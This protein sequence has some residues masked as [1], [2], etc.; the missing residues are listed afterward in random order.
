[1]REFLRAQGVAFDPET[2]E[3]MVRAFDLAWAIV[4]QAVDL[5]GSPEAKT[6]LRN[7]V[8]QNVIDAVTHGESDPNQIAKFA[9]QYLARGGK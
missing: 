3:V 8:A 1:M 2:I 5:N 9:V 7:R 6:I 4:E